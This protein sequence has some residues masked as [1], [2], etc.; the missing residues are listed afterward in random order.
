MLPSIAITID[1]LF[2]A[3]MD[4]AGRLAGAVRSVIGGAYW[5]TGGPIFMPI[6]FTLFSRVPKKMI[7]PLFIGVFA[8]L[9]VGFL[10]ADLWRS[11]SYR[12]SPNEF[13]PLRAGP[14]TVVDRYFADTRP[15]NSDAPY[16]QEH[17]VEDDYLALRVPLVQGRLTSRLPAA[18][19]T[20]LAEGRVGVVSGEHDRA[21]ADAE[22]ERAI[23][24][25]LA[26]IWT[27]QLNDQVLDPEWDF[28]WTTGFGPTGLVTYIPVGHLAP[29]AHVLEIRETPSPPDGD[30]VAPTSA[31]ADPDAEEAD[32]TRG[33]R[34][35]YIR[36]R[37]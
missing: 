14:R 5:I 28:E 1:K 2:S 24:D 4:P 16:I 12:M 8:A 13:F 9:G 37:R 19:P 20:L 17:V 27:L 11:G 6:Q 30:A 3:R 23:L 15:P 21:P 32:D 33:P 10:G 35:D 22:Y 31:P 18:C 34:I 7:W 25:C 26:A 36:F 29:G